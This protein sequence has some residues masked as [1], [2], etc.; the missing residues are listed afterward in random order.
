MKI[1]LSA[2][3]LLMSLGADL[4]V[5]EDVELFYKG[6]QAFRARDYD[7]AVTWFEKAAEEGDGE[8]QFLLGRM[9]Y[10]GNSLTVDY[11]TAYKWFVIASE[12]AVSVASRYRDGLA[13]LMKEEEIAEGQRQADDWL[14]RFS[15]KP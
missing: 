12:S 11:V 3:L 14:V 4:A 6:V 9:Y 8:A 7:G 1:L 15:R 5:A 10:D 2:L 13:H